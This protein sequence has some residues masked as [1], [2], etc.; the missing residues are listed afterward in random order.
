MPAL[1]EQ[2][3]AHA[4]H[5][6]TSLLGSML[7]SADD[8]L[9]DLA[10]KAHSNRDQAIYFESM[11]ELRIKRKGIENL[12]GQELKN[13]FR[14]LAST[15]EE[16]ATD[17]LSFNLD[18]F[19]L[20]KEDE[21]EE[22]LAIEAMYKK[23]R[24][25]N[26]EA[27]RHLALRL[28]SLMPGQIGE[29]DNPLDPKVLCDAF[30]AALHGLHIDIKATLVIYK[31]FERSV[32]AKLEGVYAELNAFLADS[33]I[34]PDI[35]GKRPAQTP[36]PK[37]EAPTAFDDGLGDALPIEGQA[38]AASSGEEGMREVFG[39]LRELL[40][41]QKPMVM[42]QGG[43]SP[44]MYGSIPL[45][46]VAATTDVLQ[47]LSHLQVQN[48]QAPMVAEGGMPLVDL[49]AALATQL[50]VVAG[51]ARNVGQMDQDVIDIVSMLFEFIL[52][53]RNLP[54]DI[55]AL[56][57]RLQ[58]PL[59]KVGLID[60]AFF[61][62][63][64]HPA[65]KLLNE[66]AQ[67]AI[68]WDPGRRTGKDGL[69]ARIESIVGR[70][71]AEFESDLGIF[72]TLLAEF[73]RYV[74]DEN[75]RVTLIEK[76]TRE[77]EE[78]K[79]KA[80]TARAQVNAVLDPLLADKAAPEVVRG[81][82]SNA[83][84]NVLF[85]VALREGVDT[86]TWKQAVQTARDLLWSVKPKR[87]D[88]ERRELRMR[89]PGMIE[90]LKGGLNTIAYSQ[91]ETAK[92]FQELEE[93]H[94]RAIREQ[95]PEPKAPE[96][97]LLVE[98]V[99]G[100]F[101]DADMVAP[102]AD[103]LDLSAFDTVELE[104]RFV[105]DAPPAVLPE[106]AAV[107]DEDFLDEDLGEFSEA[108]AEVLLLSGVAPAQGAGAEPGESESAEIVAMP[109]EEVLARVDNLPLGAWIELADES[110]QIPTRCKLVAKIPSTAKLIFVNRQG[111]KVADFT[112]MALA[113]ALVKG[114]ARL[115][116][117]AALFDRALEAVI[118]NLRKLK[119][120]E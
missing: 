102:A 20:V 111:L 16:A 41:Q 76:R 52:D 72:D 19:A 118:A 64:Q 106:K 117:D 66:M 24:A 120:S 112:R 10:D 50:P 3:K 82:L 39:M 32:L 29:G 5:Q 22:S 57:S 43:L 33:G 92:F 62:K 116:D 86:E 100:N 71:V 42:T 15:P 51:G 61:S 25:R 21:L 34:L 69:H 17:V 78:G 68:G 80:E 6:L 67:A 91:F 85:L 87:G 73:E 18:S 75:K 115:L 60:K 2:L 45:A 30:K 28:C 70:V 55:K 109:G 119:T 11:R 27:L 31:L 38:R 79:A 54:D 36:K 95:P 44:A 7:D 89:M 58:I 59:L 99:N 107:A 88:E 56:L 23:A 35:R 1:V 26:E 98:E 77:A 103:E 84:S 9:F 81:I 94:L 113:Q 96:P 13:A 104:P 8:A 37:A 108:D 4:L 101:L 65:R 46:P 114:E 97:P 110:G 48:V 105:A 93:A 14:L 53:D 40:S 47:A 12:F 49:R 83:W 74:E 63:R 90:A